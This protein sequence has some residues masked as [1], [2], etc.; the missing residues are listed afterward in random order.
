VNTYTRD[1]Y[2]LG[3][4]ENCSLDALKAAR[5]RLVK[6]WHPDR[7]PT[8][9][10]MK[11]LAE[12]RIKDINTAFEHLIDHYKKYGTLPTPSVDTNS[13]TATDGP[14]NNANDRSPVDS[15]SQDFTPPVRR[16]FNSTVVRTTLLLVALLIS[17]EMGRV[18]FTQNRQNSDTS[19]STLRSNPALSKT[20]SSPIAAAP[21][22]FTI[23]S[24]LG[25]VYA[26]QGAPLAIEN[27][28]WRYG[29]SSV[30][31]TDGLVTSWEED[32]ETPL[33]TTLLPSSSPQVPDTFTVGSSKAEVR[34]LEGTPLVETSTLWDYGLSKVHFQDD[35]VVSWESSPMRPLKVRHP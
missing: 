3:V 7:F 20:S 31:F 32:P 16:P 21:K 22:Y 12:E 30:Y 33:K 18:V 23:G 6:S 2:I 8:D 11:R 5:R 4:A 26:T 29:K 28:V 17:A 35:R 19:S 14:S 25:E 15:F 27:G 24:T 9:G 34:A 1:Y 13:S 10:E